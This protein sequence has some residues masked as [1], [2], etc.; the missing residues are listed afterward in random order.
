VKRK[1]YKFKVYLG[2]TKG[3]QPERIYLTGFNWDCGWYWGGGYLGNKNMHTHFNG[4]F[5][6]V[7]DVRGHSLG[8]FVSPWYKGSFPETA[9]EISNGCSVWCDLDFFLDDA[10]FS[11]SEWWRIKELYK[12]FYAIKEAAETFRHGGHCTSGNEQ[13]RELNKDMENTMNDHIEKNII[14]QIMIALKLNK[15]DETK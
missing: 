4:C 12:Q 15:G 11:A 3:N 2:K 9:T 7:V 10:Q 1:N 13:G 5:L 14:P 8:N 6:D